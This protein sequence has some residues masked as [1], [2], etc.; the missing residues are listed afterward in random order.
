MKTQE[1]AAHLARRLVATTRGLDRRA[2]ALVTDMSQPLGQAA[3]NALE[4]RESAEILHGRGPD[5]V[6]DLTLDL[7][8][9]MLHLAGAE[10]DAAGAMTRA[11][12]AL[13]SGAAWDKFLAMVEAQGGDPRSVEQAD[14]LPKAPHVVDV[15]A[16]CDGH[17][18]GVD[19]FGLGELVVRIGGGRAAKE[20][21]IDP[22]V[23]VVVRCRIGDRIARDA[24]LAQLHLAE[25]DPAVVSRATE[26]FRIGPSPPDPAPLVLERI[27]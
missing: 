27:E 14:G 3:G 26:C 17:L 8:A 16:P 25:Q 24:V 13:E 10:R 23:G 21:E 18:T 6:R 7:A 20:D 1:Q 22:R 15:V 5:D 12:R 9:A 4:V 11:R 2:L 19:T